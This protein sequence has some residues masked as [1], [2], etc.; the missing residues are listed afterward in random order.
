M[1]PITSFLRGPPD[2]R[3]LYLETLLTLN[4]SYKVPLSRNFYTAE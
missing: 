3:L 1:P 2:T 4:L